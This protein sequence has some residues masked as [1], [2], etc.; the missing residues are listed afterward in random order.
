MNDYVKTIRVDADP[1]I[2]LDALTSPAA[3]TAW[4]TETEGSGAAGGE[5]RMTFGTPEPM[6]VLVESAGPDLVSWS[7]LDCPVVEDWNGTR[8]EFSLCPVGDA[9]EVRFVH[10]GLSE[11][12]DCHDVC[13]RSWDHFMQSLRTYAETGTGMPRGSAEDLAWRAAG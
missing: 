1:A 13:S 12:L 11:E 2:V 6:R 5:L 7:V 10:H 9:V 4:W 3:I 8:P